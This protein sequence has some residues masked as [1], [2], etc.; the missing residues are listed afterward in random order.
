[1]AQPTNLRHVSLR[2]AP[3]HRTGREV[4]EDDPWPGKRVEAGSSI[5]DRL[6]P[7]IPRAGASCP[8]LNAIV[9]GAA[10]ILRQPMIYDMDRLALTRPK[11]DPTPIFEHFRGNY[12]SELLTIAVAHFDIFGRFSRKRLSLDELRRELN[13]KSRPMIV[14][15]TVLRAMGLL[16][17]ND[18]L[19]SLTDPAKE[20][21]VPGGEFD[22]GD[23]IGLAA[24]SPGVLGM[25]HLLK[26][27]RPLG[28]D[29]QGGTAFIYRDGIE[30]AMEAE[31]SAKHFTMALPDEPRMSLP[32][33]PPPFRCP[34]AN[35]CSMLAEAPAST[36]TPCCGKTPTC[37]LSSSTARKY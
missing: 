28:S 17:E 35:G 36:A 22:C 19:L 4:D 6:A 32:R 29:E 11:S 23:Y 25:L 12:G 30:S 24:Q 7:L 2:A 18:G 34:K 21:L 3:I 20:H 1:M 14:L 37:E 15:V 13:L 9:I 33:W 27:N 16:V 31:E 26:T 10:T 5:R 8:T